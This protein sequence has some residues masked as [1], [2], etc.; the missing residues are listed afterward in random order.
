[1]VASIQLWKN[2]RTSDNIFTFRMGKLQRNSKIIK[3]K[4]NT[5]RQSHPERTHTQARD[6]CKKQCTSELYAAAVGAPESKGIASLL[7][8]LGDAMKPV[9]AIDAKATE[10]ILHRQGIGRLKHVD[11]A[12]CGD[13]M[14]SHPKA[15]EYAESRARNTLQIWRRNRSAKQ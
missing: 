6:D 1:M 10:H 12:Y 11:V 5:A 2:G 9:L 14:K 4:R 7:K 3:R 8:D 15:C 13:K